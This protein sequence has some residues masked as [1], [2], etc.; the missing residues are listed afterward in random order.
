[1]NSSKIIYPG[2][3]K[4]RLTGITQIAVFD[5]I[6]L[7]NIVLLIAETNKSLQR[8]SFEMYL[9]QTQAK[10]TVLKLFFSLF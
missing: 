3:F 5:E 8:L 2:Y 9:K 7:E 4:N 10:L 1:M 6:S